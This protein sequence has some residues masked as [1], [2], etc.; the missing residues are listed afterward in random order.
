MAAMKRLPVVED[1][2]PAPDVRRPRGATARARA[3]PLLRALADPVRLEL[4]AL[5]AARPEPLCV[6]DI[7]AQF[8]LAQA[9]IS[10]HLKVLREAGLLRV[11]RRGTWSYYA[12]EPRGSRRV[13]SVLDAVL[14]ASAPVA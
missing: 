11:T 8:D 2:A 1:C 3:V 12:L 7:V 4:L 5:V 14:P 6:C 9:T 13:R 10:H